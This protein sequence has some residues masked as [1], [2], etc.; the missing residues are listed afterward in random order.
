MK[1]KLIIVL[2]NDDQTESIVTAARENGA[3]G[4]TVLTNAR[5]EGLKKAKTFLGLDLS[6]A[7]DMILTLVEEHMS[8]TILETIA[9]VGAF[10]EKPGTGIAFMLDI[11][12]AVGLSSQIGTISSEYK[13]E[14]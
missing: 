2:V 12:D 5:G 3:T 13:D 1:F 8:R 4:C 7:R 9:E 10:E 6:G 14:L 11:E